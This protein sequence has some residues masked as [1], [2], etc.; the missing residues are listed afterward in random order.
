MIESTT[1]KQQ[2]S[3][4]QA[5]ARADSLVILD[6]ETTGLSPD[7]GDRA[8]EIGAIRLRNGEVVDQFQALMNPGKRVS[9]FI[10]QYTGISNTM[11]RTAS[12]CAMVMAEFADY[13]QDDNLLAHNA[14]FDK[15][16]LDAEFARI[17]HQY[18][19]EFTC[20]LLAS[21]R[22]NQTLNSHKLGDLITQFGI[23]GSGDFHRALFDSEMTTKLWLTMLADV[24]QRT[25]LTSVPFSLMQKLCK[26]AKRDVNKL[27]A[28]YSAM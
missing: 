27:L 5:E 4:T 14:S 9:S 12:P 21:R 17:S 16:L 18:R 20:S 19:G 25:G 8:I 10:E 13:L 15:R 28:S 26:T 22:L 2:T 7:Q 11:L 3:N 24:K 6:F 23:A 1:N